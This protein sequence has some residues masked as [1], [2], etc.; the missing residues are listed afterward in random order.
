MRLRPGALL[1]DR[2]TDTRFASSLPAAPPPSRSTRLAAR[3][4]VC[5]SQGGRQRGLTISRW[6]YA[7]E[8]QLRIRVR[9]VRRKST[10]S[11]INGP[12]QARR[13]MSRRFIAYRLSRTP[14]AFSATSR[15]RI[16]HRRDQG[17]LASDRAIQRPPKERGRE[18]PLLR[19]TGCTRSNG[20]R[21]H[22]NKKQQIYRLR[23]QMRR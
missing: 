4:F 2:D 22:R 6:N 9:P 19:V 16:C 7:T 14:L 1:I 11:I 5:S 21:K 18:D 12:R 20:L 10:E 15:E 13:S 17:K 8:T 23:M 3:P